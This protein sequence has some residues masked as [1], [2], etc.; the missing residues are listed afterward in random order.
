VADLPWAE[1]RGVTPFQCPPTKSRA[2]VTATVW[3]NRYKTA[4]IKEIKDSKDIPLLCAFSTHSC[5]LGLSA[6]AL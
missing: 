2:P 4:A 6:F 5:G 1:E 3:L